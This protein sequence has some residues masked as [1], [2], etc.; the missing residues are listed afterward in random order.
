[1]NAKLNQK[2]TE[3][4]A[5]YLLNQMELA[6]AL[7]VSPRT[8]RNWEKAKILPVIKVRGVKRYRLDRV[9]EALDRNHTLI[10]K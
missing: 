1:M 9:L 7:R 4:L 5:A 10:A 8:I 6:E 2:E 3:A